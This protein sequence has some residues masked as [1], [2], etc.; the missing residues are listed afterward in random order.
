MNGIT[1]FATEKARKRY[2]G[3]PKKTNRRVDCPSCELRL[4]EKRTA[5]THIEDEIKD[6]LLE[7]TK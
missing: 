6:E 5:T 4:G 7:D 2:E 3:K 1:V